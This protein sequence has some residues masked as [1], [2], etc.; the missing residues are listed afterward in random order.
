MKRFL[1]IALLSAVQPAA[2]ETPTF[3]L[4]STHASMAP[5]FPCAKAL[6]VMAH[7]EHPG[8]TALWDFFGREESCLQSFVTLFG[9]IHHMLQFYLYYDPKRRDVDDAWLAEMKER[10]FKI[11]ELAERIGTD[12]THAVLTIGL[13]R[14][15]NK[16]AAQRLYDEVI[17]GDPATPN[18]P[19]LVVDNPL[20]RDPI[21]GPLFRETH[22]LRRV[23]GRCFANNDGH[24]LGRA[25]LRKFLRTHRGCY[26]VALWPGKLQGL[27][28]LSRRE[29]VDKRKY[30]LNHNEA[31]MYSELFAE[32]GR[33]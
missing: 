13:E 4:L 33:H 6:G 21:R 20:G 8:M 17:I 12:K 26:A 28:S 15:L 31:R 18:W 1:L 22:S 24:F 23:S 11:R 2:A 14:R 3:L 30:E 29:P 16:K 25:G 10:V 19:Y 7:A 27:R 9:Q 5:T 32:M